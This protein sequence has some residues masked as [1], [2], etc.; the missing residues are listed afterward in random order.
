MTRSIYWRASA[1]AAM[2]MVLMST[3]AAAQLGPPTKYT[4]F[5]AVAGK[6][7]EIGNYASANQNCTPGLA[8]TI[9]VVEPPKAGTLTVRVAQLTYNNVFGCP[10]IKMPAQ[11]LSYE[12]RESGADR[13]HLIYDVS[14]ARG[15]V[16]IYD[17][18]IEIAPSPKPAPAPGREQKF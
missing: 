15:E 3:M 6:A 2:A 18:T 9:H 16:T 17:V 4:A 12:A 8:P 11:V 13:D 7:V 5:K 10:P 1:L 14:G